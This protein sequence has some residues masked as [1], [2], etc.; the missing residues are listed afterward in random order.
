MSSQDPSSAEPIDKTKSCQISPYSL[1]GSLFKADPRAELGI[2]DFKVTHT[3]RGTLKLDSLPESEFAQGSHRG[4]HV[5]HGCDLSQLPREIGELRSSDRIGVGLLRVIP[6]ANDYSWYEVDGWTGTA[7]TA[8]GQATYLVVLEAGGGMSIISQTQLP[9]ADERVGFQLHRATQAAST[10]EVVRYIGNPYTPLPRQDMQDQSSN[11]DP[12]RLWKPASELG[13]AIDMY[14]DIPILTAG[15]KTDS[16]CPLVRTVN[17]LIGIQNTH[18]GEGG[19]VVRHTRHVYFDLPYD[20]T[21]SEEVCDAQQEQK[22]SVWTAIVT[23]CSAIDGYRVKGSLGE[24]NTIIVCGGTV[25]AARSRGQYP[26]ASDCS[27]AE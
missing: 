25:L 4:R 23:Q 16:L 5:R 17:N 8:P 13:K 3:Q 9:G 6:D 11:L 15:S 10:A 21:A 12:A 27:G 19:S 20:V 1:P 2:S 24:E 22:F 7:S 14:G 26:T 18:L